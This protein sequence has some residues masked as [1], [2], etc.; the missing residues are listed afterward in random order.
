MMFSSED[1]AE[2]IE[3]IVYNESYARLKNWLPKFKERDILALFEYALRVKNCEI[4]D[5][6]VHNCP[7]L[8]DQ[9]KHKALVIFVDKDLEKL[10][11]MLAAFPNTDAS[12][13]MQLAGQT[14][15]LSAVKTLQPFANQASIDR[16]FECCM[17]SHHFGVSKFLLPYI[18]EHGDHV[19]SLIYASD[20]GRQDLF[21]VL[22]TVA[23][24]QQ[25]FENIKM[26]V[27]D[28]FD[29]GYNIKP[30]KDRLEMDL[31]NQRIHEQIN[32]SEKPS[33]V[34]KI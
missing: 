15:N 32:I 33:V 27:Q 13:A 14:A 4:L 3:E 26:L 5:I 16:A 6:L 9:H 21:D 24:A 30:I 28:V 10:K 12:E 20:A 31:Q 29:E 34:R 1:I 22:Y 7:T 23:R 17:E 19:N 25:A 2:Y 11:N 18:S 8:S